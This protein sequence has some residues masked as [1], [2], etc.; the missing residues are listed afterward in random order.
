M[1]LMT[2]PTVKN[3]EAVEMNGLAF[4]HDM[5]QFQSTIERAYVYTFRWRLFFI[6][7]FS[8]V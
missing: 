5:V 8:L 2:K 4:D 6:K 3:H 7:F 1:G